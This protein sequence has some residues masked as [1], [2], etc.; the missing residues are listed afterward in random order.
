M[1]HNLATNEPSTTAQSDAPSIV[2]ATEF[3]ENINTLW[4]ESFWVGEGGSE[5]DLR[6]IIF[7]EVT[8]RYFYSKYQFIDHFTVPS[9][10]TMIS[11]IMLVSHPV[12]SWCHHIGGKP[13]FMAVQRG[14]V[15]YT[16]S[17]PPGWFGVDVILSND[18]VDSCDLLPHRCWERLSDKCGGAAIPLNP[19][20]IAK[21]R[22]FLL[23][24]RQEAEFLYAHGQL[25]LGYANQM[26]D[27][28][29]D[30]MHLLFDETFADISAWQYIRPQ[31]SRRYWIYEQAREII[32]S[33]LCH[34]HTSLE[35]CQ[36][37]RVSR[38]S[39]EYAFQQLAGCSP[40]DY[41]RSRKLTA[42]YNE[43]KFAK[44][45]SVKVSAIASRYGF[46]HFGRFSSQFRSL[47]GELPS[48]V[49][50]RS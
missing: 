6:E 19:P 2:A 13:D 45:G 3:S 15:S 1:D 47:F 11:L 50:A 32:E 39:L 42:I 23:G 20:S 36:T 12:I 10:V 14:G 16:S 5:M 28:L 48:Q 46:R 24:W 25:D 34:P 7:P 35:L 30:R 26:K 33:D 43:L 41:I 40:N 8:V 29:L 44:P 9:D 49:L 38:R 31:I 21:F 27:E 4:I 18:L 22:R 37:L 17:L